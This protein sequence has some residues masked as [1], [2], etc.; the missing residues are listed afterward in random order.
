MRQRGRCISLVYSWLRHQDSCMCACSTVGY[1]CLRLW[2]RHT[3]EAKQF[4]ACK[5]ML[6]TQL[7]CVRKQR[8]RDK[9]AN[10]TRASVLVV[11]AR[12]CAA[13]VIVA[14]PGTPTTMMKTPVTWRRY[15]SGILI[16]VRTT[17]DCT[18]VVEEGQTRANCL[19]RQGCLDAMV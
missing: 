2:R 18:Q 4:P 11:V 10:A 13:G 17:A 6:Y 19:G 8:F 14:P 15:V 9:R 16:F 12:Y 5:T 7:G 3:G 1:L